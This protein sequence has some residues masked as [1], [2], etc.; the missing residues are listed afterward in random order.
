MDTLIDSQQAYYFAFLLASLPAFAG[1][2]CFVRYRN[3]R[4]SL[5]LVFVSALLIRLLMISLDPYLQ[6]W[7]ERFHAL[8]AKNLIDHPFRPMLRLMPIAPYDYTS[9]CCNHIWVHKQPLFLWQMAFSMN[10]LGVSEFA[11]RLPSAIMGALSVLLVHDIAKVWTKDR[12]IAFISALISAYAFYQLELTTGRF[13]VDHNDVAFTFYVTASIWAFV[14]YTEKQFA[15]KWAAAIGIFVGCAVLTKWLTGMVVLGGWALYILLI[16]EIRSRILHYIKLGFAAVVATVIFLPWQLYI[17]S[18][19][20]LESA[21]AYAHNSLHIT[22]VLGGHEGNAF[23][24]LSFMQT[25]Y[26]KFLLPFAII[27]L[28]SVLFSKHITRA[29]TGSLLAMV[30]VVFVFFSLIVATK[31]PAFTY[32]VSALIITLI[33]SGLVFSHT[34]FSKIARLNPKSANVLLIVLMVIVS[35]YSLK[36]W[37]IAKHRDELNHYRNAE[38]HNAKI[39]RSIA[40]SIMQKYVVLNCKEFE[41][42]E[43]MF[44]H[45][46]NAH[47]WYFEERVLDSL[48]HAGHKFAAFKSHGNQQLPEYIVR[49]TAILIIDLDLQ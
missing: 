38:V 27:G 42:V 14:N 1:I 15:W 3:D 24:H 34:G 49:D 48:Q 4:L 9:W 5:F 35:V 6:D 25:A 10:I 22:E 21:A 44:Y 11:L 23:F 46:G 12:M 37:N 16:P 31:M 41:D 26:G 36:P 8:V 7:D 45:G 2:F 30:M 18:R 29:L 28:I 43:L 40:D 20:P 13:S 33:S 47:H 39:Y 32:P 17:L 19:F